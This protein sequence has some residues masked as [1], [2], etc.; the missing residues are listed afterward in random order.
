[1]HTPY[2][3]GQNIDNV[4][5]TLENDSVRLLKCFSDNQMKAIKDKCHLLS[6]KERVTMK[7]G[8]TNIKN[9]NCE[10]PLGIKIDDK[11]T[12]NEH[13]NDIVDNASRNI[14]VLS[15]VAP[16]TNE[17]PIWMKTRSTFEWIHFFGHS[18]VIV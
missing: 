3:P 6:N 1:M 5:R 7:I 14:N 2:T 13:L 11:L 4:I 18:L 15:R 16:Y 9:S 17:N 8:E 12:F 10:K